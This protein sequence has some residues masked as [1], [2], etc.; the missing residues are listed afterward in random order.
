[1]RRRRHTWAIENHEPLGTDDNGVDHFVAH[2]MGNAK[3]DLDASGVMKAQNVIDV[4]VA[5]RT[6]PWYGVKNIISHVEMEWLGL[7]AF[8][9]TNEIWRLR[10]DRT[11]TR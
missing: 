9:L 2:L 1:M 10:N 6:R 3:S 11:A 5:I 7:A 8:V 4:A